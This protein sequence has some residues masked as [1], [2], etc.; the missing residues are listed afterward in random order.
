MKKTRSK[1]TRRD[2]STS[3]SS[4]ESSSSTLSGTSSE[5]QHPK[6]SKKKK[7]TTV[8][9]ETT[10]SDIAS[11]S[12]VAPIPSPLPEES[13]TA[14]LPSDTPPPQHPALTRVKR[15]IR[16]PSFIADP[17]EP[18]KYVDPAKL[19][20]T[21]NEETQTFVAPSTEGYA[22]TLE[23]TRKQ[24]SVTNAEPSAQK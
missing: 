18:K 12:F 14:P 7:S 4:Q 22:K 23:N 19:G 11:P 9:T 20:Y 15:H 5:G 2:A 21:F 24:P 13:S 8:S 1:K 3:S 10:G 16:P 17:N 6:P